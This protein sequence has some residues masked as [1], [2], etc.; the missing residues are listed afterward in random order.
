[1]KKNIFYGLIAVCALVIIGF[2][3]NAQGGKFFK[4]LN[5]PTVYK[6]YSTPEE[7]LS[8][9]G[10]WAAIQTFEEPSLG[11]VGVTD[12]YYSTSTAANTGGFLRATNPTL[13]KTGQGTLG[14]VIVLK[15]GT[16]GGYFNIYNAT[17]TSI[18]KRSGG[19][20]TSSII[21]TSLPTDLAAGTYTFDVVFTTGLI[22]DWS[23]TIGTTTIT[24]R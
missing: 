7:F 10:E 20:A 5:S 13:I 16:A 2:T 15:A 23:G 4:F 8:D 18:N 3:V 21:I 1:M 17:T 24:Y 14:S 11:S 12:E 19:V 6:A 9:G 22:V